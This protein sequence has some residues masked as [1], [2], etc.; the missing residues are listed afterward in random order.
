M[1]A[2]GSYRSHSQSRQF[3]VQ[4]CTDIHREKIGR[5]EAQREYRLS[6][7]PVQ[8]WLAQYDR[9]ELDAEEAAAPVAE[10]EARLPLWNTKPINSRWSCI[11]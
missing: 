5:R 7:N 10:Y 8:F 1:T 9:G 6:A 11:W 4:L 2:R 3:N